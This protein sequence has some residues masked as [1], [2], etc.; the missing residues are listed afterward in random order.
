M[1]LE[2]EVTWDHAGEVSMTGPTLV[3]PTMPTTP[4]VYQWVFRHEG[5]ERRYVG[6]AVNL[7]RRFAHYRSPGPSQA[8]NLRMKDRAIRVLSADGAIE[9]LTAVSARFVVDGT[10]VEP[11]L[12]SPFARRF[13]ENA[14]LV[15]LL[16]SKCDVVNGEGYGDLRADEV[17]R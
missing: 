15:A 8:T 6:E 2:V 1:N 16:A 5:R 17:L 9:I 3:T 4:G 14:A 11:D 10:A 7:A 12:A 13:I